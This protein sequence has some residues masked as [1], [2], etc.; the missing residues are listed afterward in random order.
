MSRIEKVVS[1]GRD[2]RDMPELM[3]RRARARSRVRE[4]RIV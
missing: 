4:Q 1:I 2:R 3:R